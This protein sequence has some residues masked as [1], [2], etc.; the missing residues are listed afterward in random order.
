MRGFIN[1]GRTD[2]RCL[3]DTRLKEAARTQTGDLGALLIG[4]TALVGAARA[5]VRR[6][7]FYRGMLPTSTFPRGAGLQP[8]LSA[9]IERLIR[10]IRTS[11]AFK[12]G[13]AADKP[14]GETPSPAP[15]CAVTGPAPQAVVRG[16]RFRG[17]CGTRRLSAGRQ[18]GDE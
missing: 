16:A 7:P 1:N 14:V 18:P 11:A 6:Q 15:Y 8:A 13:T 2:V 9:L 10:L 3:Q 12:S 17:A 5:E 4:E